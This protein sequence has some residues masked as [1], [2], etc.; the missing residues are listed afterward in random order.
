MNFN[1]LLNP[2]IDS[3]Q[4]YEPGRSLEEVIQEYELDRVVK[5]ASNENSLGASK[6]VLDII[7]HTSDLHFYPDGSG[8]TL[9]SLLAIQEGV[10]KNQLILG[11]GS[12]EVLEIIS[13]A[14]LNPSTEAVFSE[15]A[16]IVYKLASK[17]R[18]SKFHEVPALDFGHDLKSF[19]NYINEKT[20]LIF[21]ANPNNPTGTYNSHDEVKDLLKTLPDHVIVI[22]DLAYFEYVEAKDYVRPYELLEDFPNLIITRSFSKAYGLSSLRIGYGVGHSELI[23]I[24]NRI[25][26][27]F[28]VNTLAQKAA[29]VALGD[30]EHIRKTIKNNTDQKYSM[31]KVLDNLRL[32]YIPSEGNFISI[33]V[34][35]NGRDIFHTLMQE[36]VIVR[37]I[38]LYGMPDFIRVTIGTP[39]ENAFFIAALK[40]VLGL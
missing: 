27:P 19:K 20:R 10:N 39:D 1:N 34:P 9:K 29:A 13:S 18:G 6:A 2:G 21:I 25:R 22:L 24:L 7:N 15:H 14:F 36:G 32:R 28:N 23:E 40:R 33:K 26:Q 35:M 38:D 5:L 8:A 4:P 12:N 3:I 37:P 17:L 30:Q 11:N 16:F 31:Y